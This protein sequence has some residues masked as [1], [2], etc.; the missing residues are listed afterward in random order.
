MGSVAAGH[1]PGTAFP[2]TMSTDARNTHVAPMNECATGL[3]PPPGSSM[4]SLSSRQSVLQYISPDPT[5]QDLRNL[6]VPAVVRPVR[7]FP[8]A[9]AV[10]V[11]LNPVAGV[12]Q[13]IA[14]A[15]RVLRKIGRVRVPVPV[16]IP[17]PLVT[18][19]PVRAVPHTLHRH[20]QALANR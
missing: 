19:L 18:R 20:V 2:P 13:R 3:I 17:D 1:A 9:V 7:R 4:C 8:H 11:P 16:Q 14:R 10:H 6:E 5:A 12:A 15:R